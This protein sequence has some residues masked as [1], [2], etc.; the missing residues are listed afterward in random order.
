MRVWLTIMTY[1]CEGELKS[2]MLKHVTFVRKLCYPRSAGVLSLNK[3]EFWRQADKGNRVRIYRARGYIEYNNRPAINAG[4]PLR[5][6]LGGGSPVVQN[7]RKGGLQR[8][9][10]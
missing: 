8:S 3:F 2:D 4:T 6:D 9:N 1:F 10:S 5:R 7:L